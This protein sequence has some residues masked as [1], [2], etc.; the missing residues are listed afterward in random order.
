MEYIDVLAMHVGMSSWGISWF[1]SHAKTITIGD[2]SLIYS[3]V[4]WNI[5]YLEIFLVK[6]VLLGQG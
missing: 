3:K 6:H 4:K 2:N 5:M 1:L